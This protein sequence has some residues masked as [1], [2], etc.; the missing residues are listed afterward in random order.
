MI[1]QKF[2]NFETKV[3]QGLDIYDFG[4]YSWKVKD[5]I[6]T[7]FQNNEV[8][9]VQKHWKCWEIKEVILLHW[10]NDYKCKQI[11]NTAL[12][13]K[14]ERHDEHWHLPIWTQWVKFECAIA[15]KVSKG[16]RNIN[17]QLL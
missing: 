11:Q 6:N 10:E 8:Y 5:T 16:K 9:N 2:R 1:N 13:F 12:L 4:I 7:K 15:N 3:R 17:L 14:H